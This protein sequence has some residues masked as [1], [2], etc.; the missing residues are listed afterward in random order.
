MQRDF[1]K[2][3]IARMRDP[4]ESN[5]TLLKDLAEVQ[6]KKRN[7]IRKLFG[8]SNDDYSEKLQAWTKS[9]AN[10]CQGFEKDFYPIAEFEIT[11]L[12]PMLAIKRWN[13]PH[14]PIAI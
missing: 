3:A 6:T 12:K 11:G 8:I 14:R 13:K 5:L 7:P 10:E 1:K 9:F 2:I 4:L